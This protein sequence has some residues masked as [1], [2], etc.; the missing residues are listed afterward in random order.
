M[1]GLEPVRT[2]YRRDP[3]IRAV[4][5]RRRELERDQSDALAWLSGRGR[6]ASLLRRLVGR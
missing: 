4:Q 6:A 2:A 1:T 5:E 3:A